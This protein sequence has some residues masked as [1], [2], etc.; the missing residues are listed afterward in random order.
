MWRF[1]FVGGVFNQTVTV[2]YPQTG[3]KM[4]LKQRFTGLDVFE[5]LTMTAE[6]KGDL[7]NIPIGSKINIKDYD[8]QYTPIGPGQLLGRSSQVFQLEG[9]EID[10]KFTV[11]QNIQ[12]EECKHSATV[13]HPFRLR[14]ARNFIGYET[15]NIIRYAMN[16]KVTPLGVDEDPCREGKSQ[17]G[18]HSTCIAEG[19]TYRCVCNPGYQ[20]LELL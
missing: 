9:V 16:N 12:Y 17:C 7:P 5:Q 14:V 4:I 13:V 11:E 6:I 20:K 18:R 3:H 19:D 10:N 2:T 8:E 15:E 1:I